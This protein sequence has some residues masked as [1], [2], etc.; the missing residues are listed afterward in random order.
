MKSSLCGVKWTARCPV[1]NKAMPVLNKYC[2][3]A[4]YKKDSIP[5][6]EV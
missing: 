1:C 6:V 5:E 3:I 4:C 2:S